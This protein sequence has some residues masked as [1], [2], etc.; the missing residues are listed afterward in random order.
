MTGN[1]GNTDMEKNTGKPEQDNP[2]PLTDEEFAEFQKK[3]SVK[4]ESSQQ[5]SISSWAFSSDRCFAA[6]VRT[7]E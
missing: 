1:A 5:L 3:E 7:R 6:Q 2:A 4:A